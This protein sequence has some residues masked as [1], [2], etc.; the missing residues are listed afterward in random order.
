MSAEGVRSIRLCAVCFVENWNG[1][2]SV[3]VNNNKIH[4]E[5]LFFSHFKLKCY[6]HNEHFLLQANKGIEK[7]E[8][9]ELAPTKK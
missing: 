6:L 7:N 9:T 3:N 8:T 2:K 1:T 5:N 4:K